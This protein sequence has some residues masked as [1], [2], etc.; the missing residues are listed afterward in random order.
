MFENFEIVFPLEIP[1]RRTGADETEYKIA[2]W[3]F[4][5]NC[6]LQMF[7]SSLGANCCAKNGQLKWSATS[8]IDLRR[9]Y[10]GQWVRRESTGQVFSEFLNLKESTW[11]YCRRKA[12]A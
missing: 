4:S 12:L 10:V 2:Q 9:R 5:L 6:S 11:K 3:P 7:V 8:V 1:S